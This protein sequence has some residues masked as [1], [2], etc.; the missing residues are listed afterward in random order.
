MTKKQKDLTINLLKGRIQIPERFSAGRE[1]LSDPPS[2]ALYCS[3]IFFSSVERSREK[4]DT[5]S[6]LARGC[7]GQERIRSEARALQP[8]A[9]ARQCDRIGC[10]DT[11]AETK[12]VRE[13][14]RHAGT[15]AGELV[16]G[17]LLKREAAA[18][19][20][21]RLRKAFPEV[22]R[23][24]YLS[25]NPQYPADKFSERVEAIA[26][27]AGPCPRPRECT[28]ARKSLPP[29]VKNRHGKDPG[30]MDLRA[31]LAQL[32]L[33]LAKATPTP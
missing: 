1:V 9:G 16:A 27:E 3:A 14:A 30:M 8:P 7:A 31:R 12:T 15:V 23:A 22:E 19:D 5:S 18:G 25:G 26:E 21:E 13:A 10:L 11:M 28:S 29:P 20:T 2:L 33:D 24:W 32:P 6:R 4:L 17:A